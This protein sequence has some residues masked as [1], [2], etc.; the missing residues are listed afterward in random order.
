MPKVT[1]HCLAERHRD[2]LLED[3]CWSAACSQTTSSGP[4]VEESPIPRWE[5]AIVKCDVP[6]M[7]YAVVAGPHTAL[8]AHAIVVL[9]LLFVVP[10]DRR[11][12]V[13]Q[14]FQ[15]HTAFV[16]VENLGASVERARNE[17]R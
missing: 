3:T 10:L 1:S 12:R 9:A 8:C 7:P 16:R 6:V 14:L 4:S 5:D 11:A 13:L 2:H 17:R 15:R